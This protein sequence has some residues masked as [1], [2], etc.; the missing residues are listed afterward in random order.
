LKKANEGVD[1]IAQALYK[2]ETERMELNRDIQKCRIV[3]EMIVA[4]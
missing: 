3:A 2:I 1:S 4:L